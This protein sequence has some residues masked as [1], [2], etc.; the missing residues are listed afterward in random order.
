MARASARTE[1]IAH[2][3]PL[4]DRL[5]AAARLQNPEVRG[6]SMFGSPSLF[7][8]RRMIGCVFGTR[9]GL[10]LPATVAAQARADGS[11]QPF[12]PYGKPAMR[13]WIEIEGDHLDRHMSLIAQAI[14]FAATEKTR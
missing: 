14:R 9:I 12:R 6:G 2:D 4:F 1:A 8:G 7:L 10:K 11:A 3:R 5:L 13:E